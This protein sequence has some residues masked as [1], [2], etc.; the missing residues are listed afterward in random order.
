MTDLMKLIVTALESCEKKTVFDDR[1]GS[2]WEVYEFDEDLVKK[3]LDAIY[4]M[5]EL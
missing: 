2:E 4:E 5:G 1:N 3:A